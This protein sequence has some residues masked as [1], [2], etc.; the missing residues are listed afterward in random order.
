MLV[1]AGLAG[2]MTRNVAAASL[3]SA[4][5][6][7][8]LVWGRAASDLWRLGRIDTALLLL[9]FFAVILFMEAS[10]T[11]I[12]FDLINRKLQGK[13]DDLT[14][15]SRMRLIG[16]ARSQFYSFGRLITG[17]FV[18]TLSLLVLGDILSV[19][20]NQ[21][22]FSA[23]LVLVAVAALVVLVTYGREP[24]DLDRSRSESGASHSS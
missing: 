18:L 4:S 17:A 5:L 2:T 24:E 11:A 13:D 19:S 7:G 12:Q 14:I 10:N 21:V 16:W 6:L 20:I 23:I 8:L 22:V 15:V 1:A 9:E 3:A